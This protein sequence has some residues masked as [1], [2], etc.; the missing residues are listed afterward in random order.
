[1]VKEWWQRKDD[2]GRTNQ[3]IF[4]KDDKWLTDVDYPYKQLSFQVGDEK[5]LLKLK[6]FLF[7]N[8]CWL[9]YK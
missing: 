8:K 2:E 1:M 9:L 7:K 4:E 5:V 3:E 6:R